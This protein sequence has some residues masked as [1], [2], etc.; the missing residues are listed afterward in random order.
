[1]LASALGACGTRA[2]GTTVDVW[3][4][5]T[6]PVPRAGSDRDQARQQRER[7]LRQ[8]DEVSA[9]LQRLGGTE[10]ARVRQTGN[11]IAVRIDATVLDQVRMLPGVRGVRPVVKLHPPRTGQ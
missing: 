6:E 8:Q 10:L 2:Q 7:V 1:V 9:Q 4:D 11:A 5:L 3:I